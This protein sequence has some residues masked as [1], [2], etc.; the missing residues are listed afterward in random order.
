M[1]C[2]EFAW[3][4]LTLS[5]QSPADDQS[6]Q[7]TAL[8]VIFKPKSF[9]RN[10]AITGLA[11]GPLLVLQS[12]GDRL[13]ADQKNALVDDVFK[14]GD[15]AALSPAHRAV[16]DS[17]QPQMDTLK[18][19]Y[20][21][22]LAE[23]NEGAISESNEISALAAQLNGKMPPNFS[24]TSFLVNTFLQKD[25]PERSFDYLYTLTFTTE[26][27]YRKALEIAKRQHELSQ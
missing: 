9:V 7:E 18:S 23:L 12:A 25:D 20:K 2:S 16:G 1:Y 26:E 13:T 15:A 21:L 6:P 4:L 5:S 14:V 17:L 11:E 24:P 22:V 8:K 10:G 27:G 19:Y 3:H